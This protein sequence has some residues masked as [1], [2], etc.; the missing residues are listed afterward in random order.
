METSPFKY[1]W[2]VAK[3]KHISDYS[4]RSGPLSREGSLS[5]H[6]CCNTKPQFF[7]S[8]PKDRPIQSPFITHRGMWRTYSNPDPHG[9]QVYRY[10]SI[11]KLCIIIRIK[12]LDKHIVATLVNFLPLTENGD[13]PNVMKDSH[14]DKK[15]LN[16]QS[17]VAVI[18]MYNKPSNIIHL[19]YQTFQTNSYNLNH[20]I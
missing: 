17:S 15:Q 18:F 9:Y 19:L 7:W 5:C 14:Q 8:H 2:R 16:N 6:T 11:C 20:G 10:I 4:R 3:F 13:N 1:W 12:L